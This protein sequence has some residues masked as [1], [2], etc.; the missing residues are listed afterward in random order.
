MHLL[1]VALVYVSTWCCTGL[2]IYLVLRWF[3]YLRG[4]AL[5]WLSMIGEPV[6]S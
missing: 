4:I 2:Y 6:T 3:V 1:G 5:V